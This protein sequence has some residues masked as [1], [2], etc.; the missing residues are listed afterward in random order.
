[1][2]R[3]AAETIALPMIIEA[4]RNG[5]MFAARILVQLG[6]P[7]Q[8]PVAVAEAFPLQGETLTDK[9]ASLIE[10]VATGEVSSQTGGEVVGMLATAAKI[11]EV[12]QLRDQVERLKALLD[13]RKEKKKAAER[14]AKTTRGN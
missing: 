3:D 5:D 1:M 7:K 13:E 2:A 8:R 12:E 9:A 14:T 11:E 6:L 10:L 4:A